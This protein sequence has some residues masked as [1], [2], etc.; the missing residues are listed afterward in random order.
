MLR[1]SG[2]AVVSSLTSDSSCMLQAVTESHR[3]GGL[4]VIEDWIG[5]LQTD[6]EAFQTGSCTDSASAQL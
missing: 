3:M 4:E 5:M 6:I 1:L 2:P